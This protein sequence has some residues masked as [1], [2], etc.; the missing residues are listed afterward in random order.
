VRSRAA[1]QENGKVRAA[2]G[3]VFEIFIPDDPSFTN[4]APAAAVARTSSAAT[5]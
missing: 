3:T 2:M 4:E 1:T 5:A